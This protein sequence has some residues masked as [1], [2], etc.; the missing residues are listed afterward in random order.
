MRMKW[1]LSWV[2]ALLVLGGGAARAQQTTF[3]FEAAGPHQ[4]GSYAPDSATEV[5]AGQARLRVRD[6]PAWFSSAWRF[7]V[8]VEITNLDATPLL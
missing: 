8:G 3:D 7:R 4:Q 5:T 6:T 1:T 2:V